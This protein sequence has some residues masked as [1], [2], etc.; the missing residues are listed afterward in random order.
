MIFSSLH[1]VDRIF[2][3]H[4][5]ELLFS[6]YSVPC[7]DPAPITFLKPSFRV[8]A[9]DCQISV[10]TASDRQ[11]LYG[12]SFQRSGIVSDRHQLYRNTFKRLSD[13]ERSYSSAIPA[14]VSSHMETR[15]NGPSCIWLFSLSALTIHL[16]VFLES[17][18]EWST[19]G[20]TRCLPIK[21]SSL[22][23]N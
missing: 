9:H 5:L 20:S 13:R 21:T 4:Q 16:L 11:R 12:N 14:I 15:F 10:S 3:L 23:R 22:T 7:T 19:V 6:I 17:L 8:I 18:K 2:F 1:Q